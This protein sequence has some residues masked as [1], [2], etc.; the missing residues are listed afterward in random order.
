MKCSII[1]RLHY[2]QS[3]SFHSPI[4]SACMEASLQEELQYVERQLLKVDHD[5]HSLLQLQEH[6]Q[7]RKQVLQAQLKSLDF[8]HKEGEHGHQHHETDWETGQ[9]SWSS[10]VMSVLK[11]HFKVDSLR[12]LQASA[13]NATLSGRDLV[14]IMPTGGGKSLCYQL[15]A[16]V[17]EG[18]TLV[19]SPLVSL[20]EDQM[21]A[22]TSM[23]IESAMLNASSSKAEVKRVHGA[24]TEAKSSLL[25]LYVTPEKLA[26]SKRFMSKLE[27]MYEMGRLVRIVIDEVHCA[28]QWGHD[29]R[30][31]YKILGILKRQFPTAP[32]LGLTATASAKVLSEC[33]NLLCLKMCLVFRA[34]YNRPNLFYELRSKPSSTKA[35]LK[36]ITDLIKSQFS[37][38]S[39]KNNFHRVIYI[40][41][42]KI[43]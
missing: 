7:E 34:S 9:F 31:D 29:F 14:L 16:L 22:V 41:K 27:K 38:Q 35:Q 4:L 39:G 28:S 25:L 24:M 26:K 42:Y 43:M 2:I 11:T 3:S 1:Q 23:G 33:Q 37:K 8:T 21:I 5:L 6:L 19:I 36:E 13:I 30:P 40:Y 17:G 10:K 20:M 15:P 18:I 32:I 12:P